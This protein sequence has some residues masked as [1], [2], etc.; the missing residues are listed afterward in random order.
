MRHAS[1]QLSWRGLYSHRIETECDWKSPAVSGSLPG[2]AAHYRVSARGQRGRAWLRALL[3]ASLDLFAERVIG[4]AL[5]A[6][7]IALHRA[8]RYV[9]CRFIIYQHES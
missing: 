8:A 3:G 5:W 1:D 2:I 7:G 4:M 9:R 6:A